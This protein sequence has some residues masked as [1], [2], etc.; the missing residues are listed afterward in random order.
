MNNFG[1]NLA[2]IRKSLGLTQ[3]DLAKKLYVTDK[4]VSKWERGIS[5]PSLCAIPELASVLGVTLDSLL[6]ERPIECKDSFISLE[7]YLMGEYGY[8][9][10]D[11]ILPDTSVV[12]CL[13]SPTMDDA[14]HGYP[15]SDAIGD[16]V[17]RFIFGEASPMTREKMSCLGL[18]VMYASNVPLC[19]LEPPIDKLAGE[20]E[21]V[22]LNALYMNSLLSERF[23][24]K[25]SDIVASRNVGVIVFGGERLKKYLGRFITL[26]RSDVI[27]NYHKRI[28][29]GSLKVVFTDPPYFW[30]NPSRT[31]GSNLSTLKDILSNNK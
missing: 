6:S 3:S 4:A 12:L 8:L 9:V 23:I 2:A 25:M 1:K 29:N 26:G 7:K 10:P 5:M 13:D 14:K 16:E 24:R 19:N 30:N 28:A 20:L 18:G 17:S 31:L 22:R 21:Y 11:L 15:L 27:S